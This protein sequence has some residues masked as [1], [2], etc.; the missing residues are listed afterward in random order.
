MS[1]LSLLTSGGGPNYIEDINTE[2][3]MNSSS[4]IVLRKTRILCAIR[5][6]SDFLAALTSR[7]P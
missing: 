7:C 4:K 6:I 1:G 2:K 3:S 5:L